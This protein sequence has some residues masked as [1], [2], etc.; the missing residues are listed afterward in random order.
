[1]ASLGLEI[2]IGAVVGPAVAALGQMHDAIKRVTGVTLRLKDEH[3]ALG[4]MMREFVGAHTPQALKAM[5]DRYE[6]LGQA[7]QRIARSQQDIH[8]WSTRYEALLRQRGELRSQVLDVVALGSTVGAPV[9]LAMDFESAMADVK[10]VVDFDT[11]EGFTRLGH[12]ILRMTRQLPLVATELAQ[13]AASGGQ[14]GVK[15]EDIAAFTATVAKMATAFDMPTAAAGDAMAKLVN[16][17]QIPIASI[18][19]LGDAINEL[20]N[21]SPAKASDIVATLSRVGGVAKGFGLSA[22]QTASLANAF[23][24]LGKPPEVAGTAINGMLIKLSTVDKQSAKFKV[25]LQ[26]MGLSAQGL[27]DAIAQDAQGALLGFLQTLEKVPQDRRMGILVDMFGLEYADDV[28]V[29]AGS[30]K[31][32][33]DAIDLLQRK[34]SDGGESF[35]GSMQREFA[36]RAATTANNVQLLKNG[37]TEL[38]ITIGS[39][40]LPHLNA[41]LDT[42]RPVAAAVADWAKAHPGVVSAVMRTLAAL[43]AFKVGALGVGYGLNL[44]RGA[45]MTLMLTIAR[46]GSALAWLRAAWLLHAPL[47]LARLGTAATMLGRA[48]LWLGR[49]AVMNPIGLAIAGMAAAAYLLYRHWEPIRGF[50]QRLWAA[51]RQVFS[52][53]ITSVGRVVLGWKPLGL[54][55]G[56]FAAALRWLG[57]DLPQSFR[58]FGANLMQGLAQGIHGAAGSAV[59]AVG[60]FAQGL[61]TRFTSL[62]GIKSPSRVFMGFGGDIAQGA[63]LGILQAAPAVQDAAQHLAA[64]AAGAAQAAPSALGGRVQASLQAMHAISGA[65]GAHAGAASASGTAAVQVQFSPTIHVGGAGG[66]GAGADVRQQVQQAL[67]AGLRELEAMMRQVQADQWRRGFA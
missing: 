57:V 55:R 47:V 9:K 23:I 27:K 32:Y 41:M 33:S 15:A 24:A 38:G 54:F 34:G 62:L 8:K 25:A 44:L 30:V 60:D 45:G 49:A 50:F 63:R 16:V 39:V 14:L 31:T 21:N 6:R 65:A 29:L 19:R 67:Q 56:V 22:L 11:P 26:S 52:S 51:V 2:K 5:Q 1:M 61:K 46:A 20:S 4:R 28:A 35:G 18:D 12:D 17:Y 53:A 7:M 64:A 13:I 43:A 37:M 42:V 58:S 10:K 66:A 3:Q 48:L 40:V 59:A 36:A